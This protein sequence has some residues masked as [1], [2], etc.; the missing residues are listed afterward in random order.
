MSTISSEHFKQ[1]ISGKITPGEL[2]ARH[3]QPPD[4]NIDYEDNKMVISGD[5]KLRSDLVFE[6]NESYNQEIFFDGGTYKNIIFRGGYFKK[7]FF[8]RGNF[9]GYV[10]IRGGVIENLILLGGNFNHW[11]GTLDGLENIEGP[12]T[13]LAEDKLKINRF[14]IEGGTYLNN[15]WISG[16][17]I[18]S[19]EVKCVTPI[20]MHCKPNDDKSFDTQENIYKNKFDSK[21]RIQ[22]LVVSR[23]SNKNTFYHF[24]ELDLKSL[25]FE[26]FTNLGNITISKV[27][28]EDNLFIENSNLGKT[29]FIDCDFSLKKLIF[30][31]SKI[32]EIA[33]AGSKLPEPEN[34]QS[35]SFD[36]KNQKKLALSQI[37]KVYQSLG[38]NVSASR[39]QAEELNTYH[40]TLK[41]SWEKINLR[42]NQITNNHGQRW[43]RPLALLLL[44]TLF[45][46]VLYCSLLGFQVDFQAE[47][48]LNT[49]KRNLS[50]YLEFLNPIRKTDFL[51]KALLGIEK[52]RD[53]PNGVIFID[54]LAKIVNA[55]LLYQFIAAFRKF[56]KSGK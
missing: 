53:I 17:D 9:N 49:L 44:S 43:D 25:K 15:I 5:F 6:S 29:T 56:G 33:L 31:S 54:S 18:N 35:V 2:Y 27:T 22:N 16:G 48:G 47:D 55:Y 4:I 37:K 38:D 46:Y 26:N 42:L 23:Y 20:I 32:N 21:P 13:M 41:F 39:Y 52:S 28:L 12:N 34:I 50:F 30:D 45:F 40:K 10:S 3:D 36:D 24:S 11:L 51:P 8:R 1:F 19:L 7:L 14:E